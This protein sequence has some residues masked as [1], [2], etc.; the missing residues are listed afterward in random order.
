MVALSHKLVKRPLGAIPSILSTTKARHEN[1]CRSSDEAQNKDV[2][3]Q[4]SRHH[5]S[6]FLYMQAI[7][8]D[9]FENFV[10]KHNEL[11]N[12]SWLV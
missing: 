5:S 7:L 8:Y 9:S 10:G 12:T 6:N 1:L 11:L 2:H 3:K 4:L